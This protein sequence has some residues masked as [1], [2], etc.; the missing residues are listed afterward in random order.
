VAA[1]HDFIRE[2]VPRLED[3][4]VQAPDIEAVG[5]MVRNGS[6]IVRVEDAVGALEPAYVS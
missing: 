3:D 6:L 2:S 4:R 5:E 1:A